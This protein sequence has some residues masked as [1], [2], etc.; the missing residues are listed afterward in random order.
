[1]LIVKTKNEIKDLVAIKRGWKDWK[2]IPWDRFTVYAME[3]LMD[4]VC[5]KYAE[6]FQKT[7]KK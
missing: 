6:Q 7:S 1:M 3:E 2:S 5:V 4:E